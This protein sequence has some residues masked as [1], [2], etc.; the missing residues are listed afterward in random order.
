M[1][2]SAKS[3]DV[4]TVKNLFR[5]TTDNCTTDDHFRDSPLI[6]AARHGHVE[7]VRVF[8]EGGADVET[9]NLLKATA[10]HYA[11]RKGHRDVCRLLLDWEAKM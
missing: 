5:C 9:A 4:N 3:G 11:A 8:L 6:Y 2:E 1:I 10:L 7:V